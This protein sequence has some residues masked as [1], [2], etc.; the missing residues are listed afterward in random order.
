MSIIFADEP[1]PQLTADQIAAL[2]KYADKI[3][4]VGGSLL[5]NATQLRKIL[6]TL[7]PAEDSKS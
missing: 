2:N 6:A 7:Q 1:Q 3:A 5:S 4:S